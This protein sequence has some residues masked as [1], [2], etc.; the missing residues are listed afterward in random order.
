MHCRR[1]SYQ[2]RWALGRCVGSKKNKKADPFLRRPRSGSE[3]VNKKESKRFKEGHFVSGYGGHILGRYE[4]RRF[5]WC[6]LPEE[7][8][9]E[10]QI[11]RDS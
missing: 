11:R 9:D 6:Q 7:S 1:H 4:S 10:R 5:S 3:E 8:M 2:F